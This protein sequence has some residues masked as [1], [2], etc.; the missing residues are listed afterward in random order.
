MEIVYALI[1]V[2]HTSRAAS[3]SHQVSV[4]YFDDLD[5]C[6]IALNGRWNGICIPTPKPNN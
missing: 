1:F 6:E 2:A 5:S 3:H 4:E